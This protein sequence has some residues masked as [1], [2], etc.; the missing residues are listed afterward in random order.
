MTNYKKPP[1]IVDGCYFFFT[2][3]NFSPENH[4]IASFEKYK[5]FLN[6]FAAT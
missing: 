5:H 6:T 4:K 3:F 2:F 1:K